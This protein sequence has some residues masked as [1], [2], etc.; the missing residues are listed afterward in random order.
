MG[1][2]F[3]GPWG[4]VSAAAGGLRFSSVNQSAAWMPLKSAVRG[5]RTAA[6]RFVYT[7]AIFLIFILMKKKKKRKE[8]RLLFCTDKSICFNWDEINISIS[9]RLKHSQRLVGHLRFYTFIL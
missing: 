5:E 4:A 6:Y 8:T 2:E 9:V 1:D 7:S 3:A